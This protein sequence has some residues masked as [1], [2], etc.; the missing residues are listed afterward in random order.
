MRQRLDIITQSLRLPSICVL[1]NQFHSK[2]GVVCVAC[3][4]LLAQLPA[5]CQRCALPLPSTTFPLCGHCIKNPPAFDAVHIRYAFVHHLRYLIHQF[6]YHNGLYLSKFLSELI[7]EAIDKR[8]DLTH[9]LVPVPMHPNRLKKRGFNQAVILA[10]HLKTRLKIPINLNLCIKS[11]DTTAQMTLDREARERNLRQAF[12][13]NQKPPQHIAII[14]DLLT[15]GS[16]AHELAQSLK[17]A[18]A[19]RVEVWCCARTI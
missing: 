6:K 4:T 5:G 1:C 14:D 7:L 15:T 9:C 18:G 11:L 2:N 17:K 8:N 13:I 19:V 16:T 12:Q 10:Q 3:Q